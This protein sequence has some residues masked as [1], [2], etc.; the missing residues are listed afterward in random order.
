MMMMTMMMMVVV[1]V[2]V[3]VVEVMEQQYHK[4][5]GSSATVLGSVGLIFYPY[6]PSMTLLNPLCVR[7]DV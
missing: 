6:S 7:A 5:R 4:A 2:V 1:V 3:V